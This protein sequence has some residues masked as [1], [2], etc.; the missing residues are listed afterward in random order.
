MKNIILFTF[1]F[2]ILGCDEKPQTSN[3]Q[4]SGYLSCKDDLECI[5]DNKCVKSRCI[6]NSCK[7]EPLLCDDGNMQTIDQCFANIGCVSTQIECG[8]GYVICLD[9]CVNLSTSIT[10]CGACGIKCDETHECINGQC[11]MRSK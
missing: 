9:T 7:Y 11:A 1:T 3:S 4:D 5:Q 2:L 8:S 10:N 6:D